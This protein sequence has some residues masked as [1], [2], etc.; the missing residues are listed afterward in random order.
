MSKKSYEFEPRFSDVER[1]LQDREDEIRVVKY[2]ICSKCQERKPVSFFTP[3]K[4]NSDG[5]A[6]SCKKCRGKQ[7]L[8][9]YYLNRERLLSE[10]KEARK[11]GTM[12]RS[13]Y[14]EN[15]RANHKEH[16]KKIASKWYK[17]NKK[18][19]K[20]RNLEYFEK[21]REACQAIREL[22]REN[23]KEEL[24]KYNREYVRTIK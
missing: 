23:H 2:K 24:K 11:M 6:S 13:E 12:D 22:W 7:A 14:Y 9:Y 20:K 19:I 16:L 17:K 3:D 21:N 8:E 1:N 4:R 5:K 18:K 15:Y 10:S